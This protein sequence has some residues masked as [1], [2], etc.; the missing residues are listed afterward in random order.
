[1]TI[2]HFEYIHAALGMADAVLTAEQEQ[3]VRKCLNDL[4]DKQM[5]EAFYGACGAPPPERTLTVDCIM[6]PRP[7]R[8]HP[9]GIVNFE[10]VVG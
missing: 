6:K 3:H 2:F 9:F 5:R 8:A 10:D 7:K 1:M 4:I